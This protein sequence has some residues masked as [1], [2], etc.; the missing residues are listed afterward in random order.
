MRNSLVDTLSTLPSVSLIQSARIADFLLM[1]S[2]FHDSASLLH[3]R[4]PSGF[5]VHLVRPALSIP[6]SSLVGG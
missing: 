3:H 4:S 6:D 5:A 2:W 1:H